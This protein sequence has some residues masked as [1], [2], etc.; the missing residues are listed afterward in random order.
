LKVNSPERLQPRTVLKGIRTV[1]GLSW[2]ALNREARLA[3]SSGGRRRWTISSVWTR[4]SHRRRK[5][6]EK[7]SAPTTRDFRVAG[8][9]FR[10]LD[11]PL[12]WGFGAVQRKLYPEDQ[13]SASDRD[14]SKPERVL[15]RFRCARQKFTPGKGL[16]PDRKEKMREI[17]GGRDF[18]P[19]DTGRTDSPQSRSAGKKICHGPFFVETASPLW[20]VTP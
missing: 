19:Y 16:A 8:K 9:W 11:S 13:S 10:Q 2:R 7:K 1:A 15:L 5:R 18:L 3:Q 20:G 12:N 6:G 4:P 14:G 17:S